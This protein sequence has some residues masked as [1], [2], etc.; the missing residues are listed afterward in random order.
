MLHLTGVNPV[1]LAPLA[2]HGPHGNKGRP[3]VTIQSTLQCITDRIDGSKFNLRWPRCIN[4][5][6]DQWTVTATRWSGGVAEK[7]A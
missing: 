4:H 7:Y 2:P 3:T 1:S 6:R 5:P